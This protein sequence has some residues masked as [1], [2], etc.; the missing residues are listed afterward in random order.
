MVLD[1]LIDNVPF[2]GFFCQFFLHFLSIKQVFTPV[3]KIKLK[4]HDF[5]DFGFDRSLY[6]GSEEEDDQTELPSTRGAKAV[7]KYMKWRH[8]ALNLAVVMAVLTTILITIKFGQKWGKLNEA[9]D[10]C[11][12]A[13]GDITPASPARRLDD[14]SEA[15]FS[16]RYGSNLS[17]TGT[18]Q[19]T[20]ENT[21]QTQP[22]S[23]L[24]SSGVENNTLLLED[25]TK[26]QLCGTFVTACTPADPSEF[27]FKFDSDPASLLNSS[28]ASS[29]SC[30]M[31]THFC[32]RVVSSTKCLT[33][34]P[35][36][37]RFMKQ[38]TEAICRASDKKCP[39]TSPCAG[40]Y[41][42]G[43]DTDGA[44][45]AGSQETCD[46][47]RIIEDGKDAF[48]VEVQRWVVSSASVGP[49][50]TFGHTKEVY[51]SRDGCERRAGYTPNEYVK[52]EFD[53]S[54]LLSGGLFVFLSLWLIRCSSFAVM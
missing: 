18:C 41:Y 33:R 3:D 53:V 50:G 5:E 49:D 52:G 6:K 38:C 10:W 36:E 30:T 14:G 11:D 54:V 12:N 9:K 46:N 35:L 32:G 34:T 1:G 44:V 15:F 4:E 27:N 8:K 19:Y 7:I 51:S 21:K 26:S 45:C 22:L 24:M 2:V 29:A 25:S 47:I 42:C 28:V 31:G 17:S 43:F 16:N 39:A 37:R 40:R 13:L 48:P 20:V 23:D